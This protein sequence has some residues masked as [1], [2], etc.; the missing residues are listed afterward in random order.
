M[1]TLTLLASMTA[2]A[3]EGLPYGV[4]ADS[5]EFSYEQRDLL[6]WLNAVRVAPTQWDDFL[7][8]AHVG[9]C[10]SADF[11]A[12]ELSTKGPLAHNLALARVAG[13]HAYD[14]AQ[15]GGT[16]HDSSDGTSMDDRVGGV[17]DGDFAELL[18]VG[19]STGF[20]MVL[21]QWVCNPETRAQIM[22]SMY[23]EAG[24]GEHNSFWVVDLGADQ[25]Q[26]DNPVLNGSHLVDLDGTDGN[27]WHFVATV[28]GGSG[29]C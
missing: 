13:D 8:W 20:G 19:Y 23:N 5:G 11:T 26:I 2:Q 22:G 9:D 24:V 18:G 7:F 28:E 16:S 6:T 27:P 17:Y 25:P 29:G 4:P 10:T 21:N 14:S 1:F 12:D 3:S 15:Q